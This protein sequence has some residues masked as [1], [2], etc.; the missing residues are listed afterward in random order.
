MK[1]RFS[2]FASKLGDQSGILRLMDDLGRAM[3]GQGMRYMLGG[4]N[5]AA[6]PEVQQRFRAIM[7]EILND[8]SSFEQMIGNYDTP[9]GRPDFLNSLTKYL[10]STYGWQI[11]P[12]HIAVTSGSQSAFFC[13]FNMFGGEM[14]D[15]S[16]KK[17]LLPLTP[18][19]IGYA[20]QG[21]NPDL[22]T[23]HKPT[24][25]IIGE[26]QFKYRVNFEGLPINQEIGAIAVSRPTNPTGNVLT[27]QEMQRLH[28]LAKQHGIP[29][30]VDNAYGAPFPSIL[31]TEIDPFWA[32]GV[33]LVLSL[34]KLGLPGVRTGIVIADPTIIKQLYGMTAILNL[35][36]NNL[37]QELV[38]R[39]IEKDELNDLAQIK[40][41]QFY[42][43]RRN[44]ALQ[45]INSHFDPALPYR[46]HLCEGSPF[47]WLWFDGLPISS[48]QLYERL[49]QRSVLIV[50]GE[51]FFFGI[52]EG[53]KHS[54]ECIRINY[55]Q[56]EEMVHAGLRII[57]E[58]VS[59]AYAK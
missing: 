41:R 18:E 42:L 36:N 44:S 1:A 6:I 27:D 31:F 15:G 2:S 5:P 14:P 35:A 3:S 39:L 4:G 17:I 57:A 53:W 54:E 19:Y 20:D 59:K 47:L 7:T 58:E 9:Q 55:S 51:Y 40:I 11:T 24:V 33:I 30:I 32:D 25:E 22:F 34:S 29:L 37:G 16:S 8:G 21:I 48:H 49:K 38:S 28:E 10:N 50:P 46:A 45:V 26:H 56:P 43:E 52:P 12:D 23:A 13:L